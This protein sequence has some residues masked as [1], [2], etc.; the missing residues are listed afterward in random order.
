MILFR[1]AASRCYTK[2]CVAYVICA[3]S[4]PTSRVW[5]VV[6]GLTSSCT[7][8]KCLIG[9]ETVVRSS[10]IQSTH[11]W[12]RQFGQQIWA[13]LID[14][15]HGQHGEVSSGALDLASECMERLITVMCSVGCLLCTKFHTFTTG[16]RRRKRAHAARSGRGRC[17][18]CGVS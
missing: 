13:A 8:C 14:V 10:A 11:R 12:C 7:K 3:T 9:L 5:A 4:R 6:L 1:S 16:G 15:L 2:S 17:A 18:T